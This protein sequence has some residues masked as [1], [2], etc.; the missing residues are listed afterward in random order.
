MSIDWQGVVTDFVA[1]VGGGGVCV[2]AVAWLLRGV[3]TGRL[4][5]SSETEIERVKGALTRDLRTFEMQLKSNADGEIERLKSALQAAAIEHQVRFS[6]L[7]EKRAEVIADLYRLLVQAEME[8]LRYMHQLGKVPD[9]PRG[10]DPPAV[11]KLLE[12]DK[13]VDIHRIYLPQHVCDLLGEL[14]AKIRTPVVHGVVYG[15]IDY[16]PSGI[17]A[18]KHEGFMKALEAFQGAIPK[19]RRTLEEEFRAMLGVSPANSPP[20]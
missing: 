13:F 12:L 18:E 2:A 17:I 16:A 5:V 11:R 8:G 15:D 9:D 1:T 7:H 20:A 10:Q 3:I 4:R 19:T 6:K 14:I